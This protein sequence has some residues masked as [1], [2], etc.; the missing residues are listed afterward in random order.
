M[1]RDD[2]TAAHAR[3][4]NL[5]RELATA[6]S[7]GN[8]DRQRIAA[9]TAQLHAARDALARIG[10]Q[11]QMQAQMPYAPY[12]SAPSYIHASRSSTV[13]VLGI[14]SLVLCH[15][16]GP[17]AWSMGNEELRRIDLGQAP[18]LSRGSVSAGRICGIIST[19][20]LIFGGFV[21]VIALLF[22]GMH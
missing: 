4:E 13:L 6:S 3:L 10:Q 20:M 19:A 14:L 1:Y 5:E 21:L 18:D 9:L 22:A 16:L 8:Q 17:I 2:L 15:M 12:G 11:Q 7:Q